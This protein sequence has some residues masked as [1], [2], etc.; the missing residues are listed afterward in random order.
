MKGQCEDDLWIEHR[1][2]IK[3][4]GV[5]CLCLII[6]LKHNIIIW[7]WITTVQG[8]QIRKVFTLQDQPKLRP[9]PPK[10]IL[11]L[12]FWTSIHK[13]LHAVSVTGKYYTFVI[14]LTDTKIKI[15]CKGLCLRVAL[16][17]GEIFLP[18]LCYGDQDSQAKREREFL[19]TLKRF[20]HLRL[21]EKKKKKLKA[22]TFHL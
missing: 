3:W 15:I 12:G 17:W 13:C 8:C 19:D 10:K 7:F 2:L 14:F 20:W 9:S 5:V 11:F 21:L 4:N 22:K 6:I 18:V 1:I 16:F